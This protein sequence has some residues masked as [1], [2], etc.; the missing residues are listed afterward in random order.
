MLFLVVG[1]SS[2]F[3]LLS[4]IFYDIYLNDYPV[5]SPY[6]FWRQQW[7]NACRGLFIYLLTW[8]GRRQ[9]QLMLFKLTLVRRY[10]FIYLFD[11]FSFLFLV[12]FFHPLVFFHSPI[13]L[14]SM[15][16]HFIIKMS[17]ITRVSILR[18]FLVT[19]PLVVLMLEEFS[20]ELGSSL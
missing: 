20:F 1:I 5:P 6:G 18:C 10:Y 15:F 4:F 12:R 8:P 2:N 19:A 13:F 17:N 11:S 3:K 9:W 16:K 14:I 7:K